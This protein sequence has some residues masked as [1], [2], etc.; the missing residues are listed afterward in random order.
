[1]DLQAIRLTLDVAR[2]L[3][4]AP[5]ALA[6]LLAFVIC[7]VREKRS[8]SEEILR[9]EPRQV[10]IAILVAQAGFLIIYFLTSMAIL[11]FIPAQLFHPSFMFSCRSFG[12]LTIREWAANLS[13][14]LS[15]ASTSFVFNGMNIRLE[16][17]LDHVFTLGFIHFCMVAIYSQTFP[18]LIWG[19][20]LLIGLIVMTILEFFVS[21]RFQIM[22]YKST[23]GGT[24]SKKRI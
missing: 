17:L 9:V 7:I 12:L 18:T 19:I 5:T 3:L 1:M 11:S 16:R 2:S 20:S 15:L 24:G 23:M 13:L 14:I 21:Y 10:V 22:P 6:L 4:F 8:A